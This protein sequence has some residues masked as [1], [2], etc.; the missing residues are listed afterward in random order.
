MKRYLIGVDEAGRGPLAGPVSVGVVAVPTDFDWSLIPGVGDSKKVKP[1]NREAIFR[2]A[3]YLKSQGK[4]FFTVS[5]VGPRFI[6]QCG[7]T[8]SIKLGI[9]RGLKKL[10]LN[11][12][13][14]A[15][16]LDGLLKAPKVYK[17]QVTI[18]GG[19]RKELVIGLASILAKVRR[20]RYMVNISLKN[21]FTPYN[22]DKHKGYSTKKHL[23]CLA[24]FGLS[25]IHRKSF[26][27]SLLV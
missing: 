9:Y 6:D 19:D 3:A 26:C 12:Q 18:I 25:D 21:Q 16:K 20:D 27:R 22:F 4:L 15:V 17:A 5:L 7:I 24:R 13:N 10:N 11:P 2:Q 8:E 1:E 23:F 14:C